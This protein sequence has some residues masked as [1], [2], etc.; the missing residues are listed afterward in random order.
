MGNKMPGHLLN[1][2]KFVLGCMKPAIRDFQKAR[3]DIAMERAKQE[4]QQKIQSPDSISSNPASMQPTVA[5]PDLS[6]PP[7]RKS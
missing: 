7:K 5:Q 6:P 3:S 4:M 1:C 2:G